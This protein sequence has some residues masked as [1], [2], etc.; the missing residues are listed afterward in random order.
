[1]PRPIHFVTVWSHGGY[2]APIFLLRSLVRATRKAF[3][4]PGASRP[5]RCIST[6]HCPPAACWLLQSEETNR[7]GHEQVAFAL[8]VARRAC[9][10]FVMQPVFCAANRLAEAQSRS[11]Q[12]QLPETPE[13]DTRALP[14]SH[15]G[16]L[17]LSMECAK[18]PH[19]GAVFGFADQ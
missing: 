1:M 17:W 11:G 16:F 7:S 10:P 5:R 12:Q 3:P 4:A 19:G 13:I 9:C 18:V 14:S 2:P 8:R 6:V 15:G